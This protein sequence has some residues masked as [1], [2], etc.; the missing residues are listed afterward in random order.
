[1]ST[2]FNDSHLSI[3]TDF[4]GHPFGAPAYSKTQ[5]L[6]LRTEATERQTFVGCFGKPT[7]TKGLYSNR[8]ALEMQKQP[9]EY[10]EDYTQKLALELVM[11]FHWCSLQLFAVIFPCTAWIVPVKQLV[12]NCLENPHQ[13]PVGKCFCRFLLSMKSPPDWSRRCR[14][15]SAL[16]QAH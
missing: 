15:K 12:F 8:A 3:W 13:R 9:T 7:K 14:T 5:V 4:L 1:M 16:C 11:E 10:L 2:L 6:L